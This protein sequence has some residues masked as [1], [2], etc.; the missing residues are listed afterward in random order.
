MG[1]GSAALPGMLVTLLELLDWGDSG[2]FLREGGREQETVVRRGRAGKA[3]GEPVGAVGQR[4]CPA[5]PGASSAEARLQAGGGWERPIC[6]T[7]PPRTAEERRG[8]QMVPLPTCSLCMANPLPLVFKRRHSA[9]GSAPGD[10][11]VK[12]L[13]LGLLSSRQTSLS[14]W[15][16]W[17]ALVSLPPPPKQAPPPYLPLLRSEETPLPHRSLTS[18][19]GRGGSSREGQGQTAGLLRKLRLWQEHQVSA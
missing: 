2:R 5:A 18:L 14:A 17:R 8:T 11:S 1:A 9:K 10:L 6:S 15:V 12:G 19:G 4:D 13:F 16:R 3:A 7:A